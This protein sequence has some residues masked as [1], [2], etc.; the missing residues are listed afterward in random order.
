MKTKL[1]LHRT[2]HEG[3]EIEVVDSTTFCKFG[4][5]FLATPGPRSGIEKRTFKELRDE[6]IKARAEEVWKT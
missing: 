1:R 3:G 4:E 2:R 5:R 6:D